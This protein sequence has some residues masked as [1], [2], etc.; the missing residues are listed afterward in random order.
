MKQ[1]LA[2]SLEF[3]KGAEALSGSI[4]SVNPSGEDIEDSQKDMSS[5]VMLPA[6]SAAAH[7]GLLVVA[8]LEQHTT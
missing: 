7:L 8:G 4:R 5:Q 1:V 2:K 6:V 3:G